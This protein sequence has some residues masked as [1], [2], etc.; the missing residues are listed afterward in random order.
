M[1]RPTRR[2]PPLRFG[3][4]TV[5]LLVGVACIALAWARALFTDNDAQFWVSLLVAW[6]A[7]A[8][9]RT[10]RIARATSRRGRTSTADWL[11]YFVESALIL[12]AVMALGVILLLGLPTAAAWLATSLLGVSWWDIGPFF[13]GIVAMCALAIGA[14]LLLLLLVMV[15]R[16]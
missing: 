3:L 9:W 16:D 1:T 5:F 13:S 4:S 7:L 12:L 8:G 11:G 14:V 2:I 6:F 15:V 10:L